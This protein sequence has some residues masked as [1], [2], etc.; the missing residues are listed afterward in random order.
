MPNASVASFLVG[1]D[2]R[3]G[4]VRGHR[5]QQLVDLA[6]VCSRPAAAER[7]AEEVGEREGGAEAACPQPSF[8]AV[9]EPS[10]DRL[11]VGGHPLDH[12]RL[13][14]SSDWTIRRS[15]P[16]RRWSAAASSQSRSAPQVL[17]DELLDIRLDTRLGLEPPPRRRKH[18]RDGEHPPRCVEAVGGTPATALA[19]AATEP[20]LGPPP[21][22]AAARPRSAAAAARGRDTSPARRADRASRPSFR[23]RSARAITASPRGQRKREREQDAGTSRSPKLRTMGTGE[24]GAR[25][26][27]RRPSP[28]AAAAIVGAPRAAA[29]GAS[30]AERSPRESRLLRPRL[31]LDRVVHRQ[32]DA[33]RQHA[34][35]GHASVAAPSERQRPKVRAAAATS[36]GERQQPQTTPEDEERA[37]RPSPPPPRSSRTRIERLIESVRS[38]TTTG[39]P[40]TT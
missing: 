37:W 13:V 34:D 23:G 25:P 17:R 30:G 27:T 31:E 33:A 15:R 39:A 18:Q 3:P 21:G 9:A 32:A 14:R 1:G 16:L 28:A 19:R 36:N 35:R 6:G 40:V 11:L 38:A 4:E 2:D 20:D 12:G 7:G 22:A 26:G 24:T 8:R 5:P 29:L 10:Q